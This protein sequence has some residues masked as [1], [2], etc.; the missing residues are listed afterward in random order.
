MGSS[1]VEELK[2]IIDD[3]TIG[4]QELGA[5]IALIAGKALTVDLPSFCARTSD[6]LG[7]GSKG[8]SLQLSGFLLPEVHR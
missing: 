1:M 3:I 4:D 5:D 2:D 8:F 6:C 7:V